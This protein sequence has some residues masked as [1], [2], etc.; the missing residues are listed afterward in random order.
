MLSQRYSQDDDGGSDDESRRI[1][2]EIHDT[3]EESGEESVAAS[4]PDAGAAGESGVEH[5][6]ESKE[7][8]TGASAMSD[9]AA[10]GE[11]PAKL[12]C[13]PDVMA[14]LAALPGRPTMQRAGTSL[15]ACCPRILPVGSCCGC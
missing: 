13:P 7:E 12:E 14:S 6:A 1:V 2:V 4:S 15:P 9:T 10:L 11:V 8:S 5:M 3:R